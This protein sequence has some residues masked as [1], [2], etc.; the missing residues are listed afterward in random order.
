MK[1]KEIKE[2]IRKA[3][4]KREEKKMKLEKKIGLWLIRI[5]GL[6]AFLIFLKRFL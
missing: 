1:I 4:T 5:A 6:F 2:I 3:R